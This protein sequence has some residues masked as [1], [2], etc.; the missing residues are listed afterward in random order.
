MA[1]RLNQAASTVT[2]AASGTTSVTGFLTANEIAAYG[3]LLVAVIALVIKTA[4]DWY[5]KKKHYEL[6]R[7][8]AS[9]QSNSVE[10]EEESH[11]CT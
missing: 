9:P 5:W 8:Q 3:G 10:A 2:Y 7:N 11:R 1:E 6:A 4:T